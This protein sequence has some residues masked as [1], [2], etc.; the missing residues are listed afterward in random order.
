MNGSGKIAAGIIFGDGKKK[1]YPMNKVLVLASHTDDESIGCGATI[2]KMIEQGDEVRVLAFSSCDKEELPD[3]FYE[4]NYV[5]GADCE[6]S[7]YNFRTLTEDRQ[8]ILQEMI[9]YREKY[10][11]DIVLTHSTHDFHQDH[12]VVSEESI[13]AFKHS[14]I[15]GYELPW[16]NIE[17]KHQCTVEITQEHLNKKIEAIYVYKSQAHRKCV[18]PENIRAWAK[19][20]GMANGCDY[21]EVFEVIKLRL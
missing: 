5:L 20:R 4:A 9:N 1:Q 6:L 11:P 19:M 8:H 3:E 12:K 21:A 10:N 15:L 7:N 16:N 18:D 17:S 14:T 13:R 2:A